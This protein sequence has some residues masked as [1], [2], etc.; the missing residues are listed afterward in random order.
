MK[1]VSY[2]TLYP[3]LYIVQDVCFILKCNNIYDIIIYSTNIPIYEVA[4]SCVPKDETNYNRYLNTVPNM[5]INVWVT[6]SS[7]VPWKKHKPAG[8]KW[9][10]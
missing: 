9:L 3:D 4:Q 7:Q 1:C 8:V 2:L 10:L 6:L 5:S